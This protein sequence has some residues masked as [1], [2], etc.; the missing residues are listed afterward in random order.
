MPLNPT[1]WATGSTA[2]L[3]RVPWD[4]SYKDVVW[5]TTAQRDNYFD[6]QT[7]AEWTV[8]D[9]QYLRAGE[10]VTVPIPYDDCW[11]A[12]YLVVNNARAPFASSDPVTLCYFVTNVTYQAPN[13]TL[14]TLQ[15]DTWQTFALTM[16]LGTCY[17]ERGHVA[18]AASDLSPD[19]LP[20]T[21][22]RYLLEPEGLDVG[23]EY[24]VSR[25]FYGDLSD[26]NGEGLGVLVTSTADLEADWGTLSA[27]NL[28][29][30]HSRIVDGLP[31]G[32]GLYFFT[33]EQYASF[34]S[35]VSGSPWISKSITLAVGVPAAFVHGIDASVGGVACKRVTSED[36][37]NLSNVLSWDTEAGFVN[38]F[39]EMGGLDRF[40][41]FYTYPYMYMQL[42]N[43]TGSPLLL[44][45]ELMSMAPTLQL[46]AVTVVVPPHLRIG[47]VPFGYGVAAFDEQ[48]NRPNQSYTYATFAGERTGYVK[49]G[50]GLQA[51]VWFQSF[52]QFS[53]VNDEYL[54]Y[55]VS[56]QNTREAQYSGAGWTLARSNA[57]SRLSYN[58]ALTNMSN[59]YANNQLSN[60]QFQNSLMGSIGNTA[61]GALSALAGG[62]VGG[63]LGGVASGILNTGVSVANQD[64]TNQMF[65]NNQTT[66]ITLAGQNLGLAQWAA[67]GDYEQSIKALNAT[68]QDAALTQPSMSGQVGG[69]GF[70]M[71]SGNF[72]INLRVMTVNVGRA[73][74]IADYWARYGY[75]TNRY[76][77]VG[78][79]L[80][81]M[82]RYTYWKCADVYVTTFDGD[83]SSKDVVRGIMERGV[84]V[85]RDPR[86]VGHVGLSYAN[87]TDT[88]VA[89]LY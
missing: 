18:V 28:D 31:S 34:M 63:A 10:P 68:V 78:T 36:A 58:Q 26:V 77:D 47:I 6:A 45:P 35:K 37:V 71:A 48:A 1:E 24:V 29:T 85:W 64:L 14:L 27:P 87:A 11:R 12:N 61:L 49:N 22:Q 7:S 57:A 62:N 69:D 9:M 84:T 53:L 21:A 46:S 67:Q 59:A 81:L 39:S 55:L 17:V 50:L 82:S 65:Y 86:E 16:E 33:A 19:T 83:E 80:N 42:D 76:V 74:A 75:A 88:S 41:K 2:R 32:A 20:R 70:N 60:Q 25:N 8:T 13:S 15:L 44:K 66:A 51:A 23:N 4:S 52:P 73:R 89:A 3:M 72:G 54:N 40:K 38:I 30:A 5:W 43:N 56:T 79:S